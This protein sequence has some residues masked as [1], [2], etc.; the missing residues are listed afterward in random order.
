M[1][2][3]RPLKDVT[4]LQF[5]DRFPFSRY[6]RAVAYRLLA[7]WMFG[8]MDWENTRPLPAC[9]YHYIRTKF[10]SANASGYKKTNERT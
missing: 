3:L 2:R 9:I 4:S 8:Y 1:N 6:T 5:S 7:R 10:S